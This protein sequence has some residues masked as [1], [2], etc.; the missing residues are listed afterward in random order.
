[1][2]LVFLPKLKTLTTGKGKTRNTQKNPL[3]KTVTMTAPGLR[4]TA[5]LLSTLAGENTAENNQGQ[6]RQRDAGGSHEEG[7]EEGKTRQKQEALDRLDKK[8]LREKKNC[9]CEIYSF[10]DCEG[11]K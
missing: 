9:L 2:S 11:C 5:T 4:E 7:N 3:D 8:I 1:M 10:N 6:G